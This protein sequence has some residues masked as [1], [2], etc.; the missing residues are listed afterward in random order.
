MLRDL[1]YS[2]D[3][4]FAAMAQYNADWLPAVA[5]GPLLAA[6]VLGLILRPWP[7]RTVASDRLIATLLGA[8]WIWVG[9]VHQ[10]GLMAS[11]NFMAPVYGA[12]WIAEG[13]LIVLLGGAAGRLRFRFSGRGGGWLGLV[14]ALVGLVGYPLA[15]LAAGVDGHG[16]PL[17]GTAPHPTALFTAGLL[18]MARGGLPILLFAIPLGWAGVAGLS[19]YLLR[20]PVD[21]GV[22]AAI[23]GAAAAG[24]YC[25]TR[26]WK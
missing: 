13:A 8:A 21:Y 18:V 1:P 11:L 25:V 19:A 10:I 20:F 9:A 5:A 6:A 3:V 15:V 16:L 17:V 26:S 7:G 23:V 2:I 24:L 12:A 22:A 4:Y 14:V